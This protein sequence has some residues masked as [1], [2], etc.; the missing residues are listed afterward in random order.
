MPLW[1][2]TSCGIVTVK[3]RPLLVPLGVVTVTL[4]LVAPEGTLTVIC[5][6]EF[7]TKPGAAVPLK[8]TAVVLLRLAP[9]STTLVP[10]GPEVGLAP[11]SV[12]AGKVVVFSSTEADASF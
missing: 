6:A 9:V 2:T 5:V 11:L 7:T 8:L 3:A 12:G 1:L 10:T 4:P